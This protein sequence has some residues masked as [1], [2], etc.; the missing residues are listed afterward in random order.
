M[1]VV[2]RWHLRQEGFTMS[3]LIG[4]NILLV[5][6]FVAQLC[7]TRAVW[8]VDW[9][10][11]FLSN[12]PEPKTSVTVAWYDSANGAYDIFVSTSGDAGDTWDARPVPVGGSLA[13]QSE[14]EAGRRS[15]FHFFDGF[16]VRE[17]G[18]TVQ[19]PLL[20]S[21]DHEQGGYVGVDY[22]TFESPPFALSPG[23]R[24]TVTNG[25]IVGWPDVRLVDTS[26][27]P[28]LQEFIALVDTLPR[29][30]GDVIVGNLALRG[31]YALPGDA[32]SDGWVDGTDY[33]IWAGNY[34]ELGVG[35]PGDFNGDGKVDGLDYLEWAG[36][37]GSH[38]STSV[39]EPTTLLMAV[40]G[41]MLVLWRRL[42]TS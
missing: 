8:G 13:A 16:N 19:L 37:F 34:G 29:L 26:G 39:P 4:R 9:V 23:D 1:G 25:R 20:F 14:T 17:L 38:A 10:N 6:V 41:T 12:T 32:N 28:G 18:Q 36:N 42:G 7:S 5:V 22:E 3:R 40:I 31:Q 33:L 2:I 24:L 21:A 35:L 15:G 11:L 27:V 30:N